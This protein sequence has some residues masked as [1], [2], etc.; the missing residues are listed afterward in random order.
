MVHPD[1]NKK[2]PAYSLM[3]VDAG[4]CKQSEWV[5]ICESSCFK[6]VLHLSQ[7]GVF[8]NTKYRVRYF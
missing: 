7:H 5:R 2:V 4:F 6:K 8:K 3:S 1:D